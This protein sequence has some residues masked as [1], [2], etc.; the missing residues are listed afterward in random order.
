MRRSPFH[1]RAFTLI[2]LLLVMALIAIVVA[3]VAPQF[4]GF[5][6]GQRM[7][8]TAT[9]LLAMTRY[10]RTQAVTQGVTYR[11]NYDD[12]ASSFWISY[13]NG[14]TTATAGNDFG[15]PFTM[16]DGIRVETDIPSQSQGQY[17]EFRPTGRTDPAKI[18]LTDKLG[19][20]IDLECSSA[21]EMFRIVNPEEATR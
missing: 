3:L 8:N 11:L 12:K 14:S 13:E 6:I 21:T 4:R 1:P 17:I 10:A 15:Q 2:E 5:T 16:A 18:K 19:S 9:T 7:K 20:S